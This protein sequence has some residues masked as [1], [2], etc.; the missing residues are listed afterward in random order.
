[1]APLPEP[2]YAL[3]R[4]CPNLSG[5]STHLETHETS[6]SRKM[7]FSIYLCVFMFELM[8]RPK[9]SRG[10]FL[11]FLLE[12]DWMISRRVV[13]LDSSFVNDELQGSQVLL[14][15]PPPS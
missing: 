14:I 10:S 9:P 15:A 6:V 13:R 4:S 12:S 3:N 5:Q 1:M 2:V 8:F 7:D 11:S